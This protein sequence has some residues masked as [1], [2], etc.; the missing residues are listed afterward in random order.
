MGVWVVLLT[1]TKPQRPTYFGYK[2]TVK[3]T[4]GTLVVQFPNC[5][6]RCMNHILILILI[7]IY[8]FALNWRLET[9]TA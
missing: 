1:N 9:A 3:T 2:R 4:A 6:S 8:T 7:L 5:M